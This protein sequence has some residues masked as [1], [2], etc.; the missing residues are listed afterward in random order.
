MKAFK[1]FTAMLMIGLLSVGTVLAEEKTKEF[2]ASWLTGDVTTLEISNRFGEVRINNEG[3]DSVVVHVTVTVDAANEKKADDLLDKI[4]I[5]FNKS[6]GTAK[7]ETEIAN[8]FKSQRKF[9]IDYVVNIPS[10]KNLKISNKYGNTVV[11]RLTGNGDFSCKYGDFTA[12]ELKTPESGSLS[13]DLAYGSGNIGEASS[14]KVNVAYSPLSIE[15]VTNLKVDSKYSDI[16][17]EEVG[18]VEIESKYDKFKFEEASSVSATT[19]YTHIKIGELDKSF[20][21]ESGY[22]SIKIEE[23]AADFD[24]INISNSYG[25]ISIGLDDL[26]YEVDASCDYCGIS[27]PEDNFTGDR[28][29]EN[30]KR[31]IKGKIGNGGGKVTVKSRYGEIKLD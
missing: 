25:Q 7:A 12:Y 6:G 26:E 3:G 9:S 5:E 21:V 24:F 31:V 28:I 17:V 10:D 2:H 20:K 19:K 8:N 22:G 18:D 15:E 11:G 14:M 1:N 27:Y 4:E 13:L 30:H 23:V 16:S 29:K